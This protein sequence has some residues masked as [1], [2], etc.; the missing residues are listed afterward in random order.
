MALA[1]AGSLVASESLTHD[2]QWNDN[3]PAP[4]YFPFRIGLLLV[5]AGIVLCVRAAQ[6]SAGA[7]FAT[8]DELRRALGVF[9]PTALA[10]AG[11]FALGCYVPSVIYLAWM[12]RR[13]GSYR[14]SRSIAGGVVITAVIF[15]LFEVWFQ[16]PLAK[17]PLETAFGIY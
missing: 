15:L 9:W 1:L 17:G 13:H 8:R 11:M 6:G 4:G 7:S 5:A 10:V 2:V 14:W 3:G 16:V 12:M